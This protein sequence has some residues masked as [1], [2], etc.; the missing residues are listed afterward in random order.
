MERIQ[1]SQ[2][3]MLLVLFEFTS[4][5]FLIPTL[6]EMSGYNSWLG[7]ILGGAG[8]LL[9]IYY[10]VA[11]ARLSPTVFFIHYGAEIVGK[12]PHIF[13]S[14]FICFSAFHFAAHLLREFL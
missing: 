6:V 8:G 5:A 3:F 2:V 13:F 7:V 1:Q 14:A 10:T 4:F 12:V 11:L 9:I